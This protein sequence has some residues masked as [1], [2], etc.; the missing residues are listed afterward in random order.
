MLH[1]CRT[2]SLSLF[3][4][5]F[6]YLPLAV[7]GLGCCV[8][9]S[10]GAASGG[11]S[12]IVVCGLL[13]LQSTGSR[14]VDLSSCGSQALDHRLSSCD[15]WAELF[16]DMGDLPGSGIEPVSPVLAGGFFTAE[17]PWKPNTM[18]FVLCLTD[19]LFFCGGF[20]L[21]PALPFDVSSHPSCSFSS[22][23]TGS[24]ILLASPRIASCSP[25]WSLV[26]VQECLYPFVNQTSA[27]GLGY[28]VSPSRL[29]GRRMYASQQTRRP[30]R[31]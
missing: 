18:S 22:K 31:Q 27:T 19:G 12:L 26:P 16:H 24:L 3:K 28:R 20:I 14:C 23:R 6:I 9:F 2:V 4:I 17:P 11:C 25:T 29:Q 30:P 7:P 1:P 13:S 21:R 15:S 8:V 5:L 10:P